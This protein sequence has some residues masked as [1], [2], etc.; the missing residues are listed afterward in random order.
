MGIRAY[1]RGDDLIEQRALSRRDARAPVLYSS[2]PFSTQA[3]LN[4][5]EANAL[6]VSDAWACVRALSDSVASLPIHVYRRSP[7]G[8]VRVGDEARAVQLLNRPSPGATASDLFSAAMAHLCVNG[9]CFIGNMSE[10]KAPE[11]RTVDVDVQSNPRPRCRV[12]VLSEDLG[13]FRER[14]VPGAFT[15]VLDADVRLLVKH[16]PDR[17][18]ARILRQLCG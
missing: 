7:T 18:L 17:I 15:V 4:V 2:G 14:I 5:G 11:Q 8:R 3:P 13:G 6:R 9:N 10:V 12:H 16:D 1:L